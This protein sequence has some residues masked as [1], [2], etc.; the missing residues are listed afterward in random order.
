MPLTSGARLGPY[1]ISPNGAWVVFVADGQLRKV[2]IDGGP[3]SVLCDVPDGVSR[4]S[5]QSNDA[6]VF[7]ARTGILRVPAGGG[8]PEVAVKLNRAAEELDCR[9]PVVLP[10]GRT[11]AFTIWFGAPATARIGLASFDTGE[12][13]TL[14]QG[15]HPRVT[16]GGHLL[17]T[18]ART[19]WAVPLNPSQLRIDR[20][21]APV[22][23]DIQTQIDGRSMYDLAVD[24]TLIYRDG[25]AA[26]GFQRLIWF[27]RNA[28][29]TPAVTEQQLDG[30][31]HPS[32]SLSPDERRLAITVHPEGGEDQAAGRRPEPLLVRPGDQGPCH[33]RQMAGS[34]VSLQPRKPSR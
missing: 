19:L 17:F 2:A 12:H 18:R 9:W 28:D 4:T 21:P 7:G 6:I 32:P 5:W 34:A 30:I 15:A 16:S 31:Y 22:L 13:R 26:G 10:D 8:T 24:G 29:T 23:E 3:P 25:R 1:E 11:V 20:E 14:T 27:G 33:A